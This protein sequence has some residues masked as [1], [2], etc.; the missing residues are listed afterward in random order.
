MGASESNTNGI[1]KAGSAYLYQID[2][3]GSANYLAKVSAPDANNSDYFGQSVSISNNILAVGAH[4][5]DPGG[6][7][8]A[9]ATYLYRIEAN[10]SVSFLNKI[11]A[12]DG[13]AADHFGWSLSQSGN[14]LAVGAHYADPNGLSR[15]GVVYLY[16]LDDNGTST[17]K[18]KITAPDKSSNDAFGYSLYFSGKILAVGANWESPE[19]KYRAGAVYLYKVEADGTTSY[20]SKLTALDGK[21]HDNF[22]SSISYSDNILTVGS[23]GFDSPLLDDAGAAYLYQIDDNGSTTYLTKLTAPDGATSDNFGRSVSQSGNILAVGARGV[24]SGGLSNAG[25]VYT[26]DIS[27]YVNDSPSKVFANGSVFY[28]ADMGSADGN[29]QQYSVSINLRSSRGTLLWSVKPWIY[30]FRYLL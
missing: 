5:A 19:G 7:G 6:I 14:L 16:H 1:Y 2:S 25:A 18:S 11:T 28:P 23:S 24:D 30:S 3:N 27:G 29:N 13:V 26:F 12:H 22:G 4:H 15:A 10:G 9:G 17:F 21:S 8:S 20:L